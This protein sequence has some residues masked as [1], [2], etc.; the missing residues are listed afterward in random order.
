MKG[1]AAAMRL[2]V[3]RHTLS[4]VESSV[5]S[6]TNRALLWRDLANR[7]GPKY[8]LSDWPPGMYRS[9]LDELSAR[10]TAEV[11]D[12]CGRIQEM[13]ERA[14]A[15]GTV[16]SNEEL[17]YCTRAAVELDDSYKLNLASAPMDW[18]PVKG[19]PQQRSA[20]PD[21][22]PSQILANKECSITNWKVGKQNNMG[23]HYNL[24]QDTYKEPYYPRFDIYP[25]H[26]IA[27]LWSSIRCARLHLLRGM[28]DLHLLLKQRPNQTLGNLPS[29]ED[30][31]TSISD[32]VHDI[33]AVFPYL[34]GDFYAGLH[35]GLSDPCMSSSLTAT[36]AD[37]T[38]SLWLLHKV[39]AV[40]GIS[41]AIRT[42]ALGV[43]E[44]IGTV[45][46]IRQGNNL[47]LLYSQEQ[48]MLD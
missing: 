36:S 26:P 37:A 18:L 7:T 19:H 14:S 10:F 39:L 43:C 42:W 28:I 2:R 22:T 48:P 27:L 44:R 47:K 8:A 24:N 3:K 23:K 21:K 6:H 30:V 38:V 46:N 35:N 4:A 33:C 17:G 40:P 1:Q 31:R 12:V 41:S 20:I 5:A 25:S 13:H 32:T 45:G 9:W 34:L 15:Y 29:L 16:N 11:A